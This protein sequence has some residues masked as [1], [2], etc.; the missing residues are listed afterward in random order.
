MY[1]NEYLKSNAVQYGNAATKL[2]LPEHAAEIYN[3]TDPLTIWE[4]TSEDGTSYS[5][6]GVIDADDMTEWDVIDAIRCL[7]WSDDFDLEEFDD[8]EFD[9][10][11]PVMVEFKNE[12]VSKM[13]EHR[14][15]TGAKAKLDYIKE[16][17]RENRITITIRLNRQT[18]PELIEYW[19]SIPNKRK[20]FT[21]RL[22]AEMD[23]L[24]KA[25]K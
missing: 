20:W 14:T 21:D 12:G 7:A 18:E 5:M 19:Q 2:K 9:D 11:E 15:P 3:T 1:S 23:A 25:G 10:P 22:K 13:A 6:R 17:D 8:E 24:K 16:Y 4:F